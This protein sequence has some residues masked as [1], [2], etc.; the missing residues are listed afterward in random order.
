[1]SLAAERSFL[2]LHLLSLYFQVM[3]PKTLQSPLAR[4]FFSETPSL[5]IATQCS[6]KLFYMTSAAG[7]DRFYIGI[8]PRISKYSAHP[9]LMVG[10]SGPA[11]EHNGTL[12]QLHTF[13][14]VWSIPS[15]DGFWSLYGPEQRPSALLSKAEQ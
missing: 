5:P 6:E 9:S 8:V 1:M 13:P 14:H 12:T 4:V 11:V 7:S 3:R 2:S 15:I 10:A